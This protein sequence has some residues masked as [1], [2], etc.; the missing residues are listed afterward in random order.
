MTM[1]TIVPL[2]CIF[3]AGFVS[4]GITVLVIA[5]TMRSAHISRDEEHTPTPPS[6]WERIRSRSICVVGGR[7]TYA[8]KECQKE[9]SDAIRQSD[10]R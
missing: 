7:W 8:P 6:W 3:A 10:H 4:G 5:A 2:L 9:G 1:L